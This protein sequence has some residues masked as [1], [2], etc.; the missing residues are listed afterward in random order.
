MISLDLRSTAMQKSDIALG[1]ACGPKASQHLRS[2]VR[3]MFKVLCKD[4]KIAWRPDIET[5]SS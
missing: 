2:Y 4:E 1:I 5:E 3:R